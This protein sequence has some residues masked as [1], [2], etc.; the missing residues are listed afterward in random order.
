MSLTYLAN[1]QRRLEFAMARR[2]GEGRPSI[3]VKN[4]GP[5]VDGFAFFDPLPPV[6]QCRYPPNVLPESSLA[7]QALQLRAAAL[8]QLPSEPPSAR[9]NLP[10]GRAGSAGGLKQSSS[11]PALPGRQG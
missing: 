7:C 4:L 2:E 3:K 8:R 10:S 5:G 1:R 6:Y 11:L 9:S